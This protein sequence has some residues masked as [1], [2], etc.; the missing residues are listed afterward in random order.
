MKI[1][2]HHNNFYIEVFDDSA[3]VQ[4]PDSPTHYDKVYEPEAD[5]EYRPS[6]QHAVVVYDGERQ[7]SNAIILAAAGATSV[8]NDACFIHDNSL[9]VRCSNI[10]VSLTIPAL[11]LNWMTTADP[12]TCFSIHRYGDSYITHG[13]ISVSR[14]DKD[15]NI[16]WQFGSDDIFLRI[17]GDNCF[18]MNA[19]SISLQNF[20]GSR[21]EIDYDGKLL[22]GADPPPVQFEISKNRWW[23]KFSQRALSALEFCFLVFSAAAGLYVLFCDLVEIINRGLGLSTFFSQRSWLSDTQAIVYCFVWIMLFGLSLTA[24]AYNIYRKNRRNTII[25]SVIIC[26][27]FIASLFIEPL[28]YNKLV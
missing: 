3:Y 6:S 17:D 4:N 1:P 24:F 8:T 20:N 28:F 25:L 21:Y 26:L 7:V 15:G 23:R 19:D 2:F 16:T 14:I 11:E 13:E 27:L 10:V 5:K 22:P 12:I 9:I 18:T